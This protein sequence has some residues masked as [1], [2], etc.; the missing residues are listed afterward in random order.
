[1]NGS[2]HI[3]AL[4]GPRFRVSTQSIPQNAQ[5]FFGPYLLVITLGGRAYILPF[6]QAVPD[7][8][9]CCKGTDVEFGIC[10]E[11]G[12]HHIG[13]PGPIGPCQKCRLLCRFADQALLGIGKP[14][15]QRFCDRFQGRVIVGLFA[16]LEGARQALGRWHGGLGWT[17]KGKEF[18]H[19]KMRRSQGAAH[20]FGLGIGSLRQSSRQKSTMTKQMGSFRQRPQGKLGWQWR[21]INGG[22]LTK[23]IG[24]GENR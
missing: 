12:L 7:I 13:R 19:I 10:L 21:T 23:R 20:L 11:Q 18:G 5:G 17:N 8:E 15:E 22:T 9:P 16:Q 14:G 3:I 6:I 1:M 2:C 24:S 4:L